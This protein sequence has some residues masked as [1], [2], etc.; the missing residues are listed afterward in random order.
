[1]KKEMKLLMRKSK[2]ELL[3]LTNGLKLDTSGTKFELAKRIIM[4]HY[5]SYMK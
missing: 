5:T 1:M 4:H 3:E 2:H